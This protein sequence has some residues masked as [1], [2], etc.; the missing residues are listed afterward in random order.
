LR[1]RSSVRSRPPAGSAALATLA[2]LVALLSACA[3]GSTELGPDAELTIYL[4]GPLSGPSGADG[5]DILAG[6]RMALDS[7]GSEA[8]GVALRLEALDSAPGPMLV[9]AAANARTAIH[10][11]TAIAYL[12]D[13]ES[14]A[15]R[16]SL[17]ITNEAHL[18]HVSAASTAGDLVAPFPGSDDVPETQ[19]GG[20]RTFARVIPSDVAQ[21][22]AA[23]GWAEAIGTRR[24]SV[25]SDG[26]TFGDD[27][28]GAFRDALE[29]ATVTRRGAQLLFYG[30]QVRDQPTSLIQSF[31]G[32]VMVTDAQL[33]PPAIAAQPDGT[34]GTSAALDPSQLPPAG[35][36]FVQ[37]FKAEV[38]RRPGRY[39]AYGYEAMAAILHAI[40]RAS[41]PADRDAVVD[42]FFAIEDR[43]SILGA[44]SIDELGETTLDRVGSY[45]IVGTRLVPARRLDVP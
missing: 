7:A 12:G 43:D 26:S 8:G 1:S 31:R 24:I 10:D 20:D 28:V 29:R 33:M 27:V 2:S 32:R 34:L 14:G 25:V 40:D 37:R 18:L 36:D 23:A 22:E 9:R 41:D 11:S 42:A 21:A 19:P 6:A 16:A 3:S 45:R 39:A 4:S 30:G 44:Y 35:R 17:P 15:T 38:G 13:F 5:R